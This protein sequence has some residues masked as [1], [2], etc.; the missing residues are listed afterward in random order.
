MLARFFPAQEASGQGEKKDCRERP[1]ICG[2]SA[3]GRLYIFFDEPFAL[4]L[5]NGVRWW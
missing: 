2:I 5:G 3:D 1:M 4:Q